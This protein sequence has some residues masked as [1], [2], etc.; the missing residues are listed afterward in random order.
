M[1]LVLADG[2]DLY[3]GTG[4]NTGMQSKWTQS[5][6]GTYALVSGR[7]GGQAARVTSTAGPVL[8][9]WLRVMPSQYSSFTV[10]FA[11]RAASVQNHLG[12]I[13]FEEAASGQHCG[14]EVTSTGALAAGRYTAISTRTVLGTASAAG[15]IIS[16]TWHFIEVDVTISDTV[17]EMTVRVDGAQ[18][19]NLTGQDTRNGGTGVFDRLRIQSNNAFTFSQDFDDVL[20][21]DAFHNGIR[22]V[23]PLRPSSDTATKNFT[24]DT[25]TANYSRV[26]ETLV[27]GDTSYVQGTLSAVD[28]YNFGSLTTNPTSIDG[29]QLSAF[30]ESTD[31]FARRLALEGKFGATTSDGTDFSLST[32]YTKL[33]R[34]LTV[35]PNTSAAFITSEVNAIQAGP[36]VTQ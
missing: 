32:N 29:V 28:L 17:G 21:Y 10:K 14:L 15:V 1:A 19:L 3:N 20:V 27:D 7:L 8:A 24:P 4:T 25:G 2:F 18:V 22:R 23:T 6:S 34:L 11:F 35:N 26:N 36:K 9:S 31:A 30:A 16:N 13:L 5:G 33:E 12:L